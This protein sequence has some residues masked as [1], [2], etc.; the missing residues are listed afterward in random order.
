MNVSVNPYVVSFLQILY[1]YNLSIAVF[2]LIPIPPLDGSRLLDE[3]LPPQT[4][5]KYNSFVGRYGFY[6]LIALV[7][8]GLISYI[9][10]PFAL[11]YLELVNTVLGIFF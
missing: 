10:T 4:A 1:V 8:S 3:F 7:A 11:A 6:I 5:Y 2:N 9:I